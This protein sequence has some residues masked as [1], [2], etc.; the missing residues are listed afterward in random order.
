[1]HF[2][3]TVVEQQAARIEEQEARIE[4]QAARIDELVCVISTRKHTH[5]HTHT[6]TRARIYLDAP[7]TRAL[8]FSCVRCCAHPK[9]EHGQQATCRAYCAAA[10]TPAASATAVLGVPD[11]NGTQE[12]TSLKEKLFL[13]SGFIPPANPAPEGGGGLRAIVSTLISH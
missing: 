5:T 6:C 13:F 7:Y 3:N 12:A 11:S 2:Q 4:Q 9:T 10:G 1:M 8:C